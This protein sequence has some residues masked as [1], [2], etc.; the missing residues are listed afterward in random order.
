MGKEVS[1]PFHSVCRESGIDVFAP[2]LAENFSSC[3]GLIWPMDVVG[4]SAA[5]ANPLPPILS[6]GGFYSQRETLISNEARRPPASITDR[7][8]V[9]EAK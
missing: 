6:I 1:V 5:L 9:G 2:C 8:S 7:N 4:K 3:S